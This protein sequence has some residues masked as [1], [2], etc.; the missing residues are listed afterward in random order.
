MVRSDADLV[1]EALEGS[2]DAFRALVSRYARPAIGLAARMVRD[3]ALAEDLAQE[4]FARAFDRLA[5]YKA[6]S[7]FSAW[8]FQILHNVTI[9][10]LRRKRLPS[11]SLEEL[12][13]AGHPGIPSRAR[14]DSPS[15]A[16][17]QAELARALSEAIGRLRPEYRE[18]VLLRYREELSVQEIAQVMAIP[19]GTV[20]TYLFRGRKELAG[21][22]SVQGWGP[23]SLPVETAAVETP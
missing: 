13:A 22:L 21:M 18:A 5:T 6:D 2:Q 8:F 23:T 14:A 20:K 7:R 10:T 3:Q 11:V 17:E 1:R 15:D 4:A 16:T 19:D 12:D 9:D